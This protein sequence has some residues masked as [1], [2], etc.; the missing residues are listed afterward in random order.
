MSQ[1]AT[2]TCGE[3]LT[4]ATHSIHPDLQDPLSA[5]TCKRRELRMVPIGE[6]DESQFQTP[7]HRGPSGQGSRGGDGGDD[8]D[9]LGD[10]NGDE[11]EGDEGKDEG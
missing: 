10:D 11:D 5:L 9:D 2:M 7:H 8:E 3:T 4:T 1:T 6:G